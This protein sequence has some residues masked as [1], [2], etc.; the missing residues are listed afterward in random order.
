M[1]TI[2]EQQS[3]EVQIAINEMILN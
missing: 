2:Q 3:E 1:K